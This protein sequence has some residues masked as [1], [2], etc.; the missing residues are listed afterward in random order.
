MRR[1]R[2]RKDEQ[3]RCKWENREGFRD[4]EGRREHRLL[5]DKAGDRQGP[6]GVLLL[7]ARTPATATGFKMP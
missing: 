6:A 3:G 4:G 1:E 2:N 5:S 7:D